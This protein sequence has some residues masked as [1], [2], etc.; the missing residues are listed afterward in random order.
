MSISAWHC[1]IAGPLDPEAAKALAANRRGVDPSAIVPVGIDALRT[2]LER[3][4]D[5]GFTKFVVRPFTPPDSWRGWLE[6]LADGVLD[7][8][9]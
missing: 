8:Q 6:S 5:V 2:T 4:I 1:P 7:L 3:F 9:T